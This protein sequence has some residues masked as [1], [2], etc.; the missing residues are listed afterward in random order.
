MAKKNIF[1]GSASESLEIAKAIAQA[2]AESDYRS[3]RWW[4]EFPAGSITLD[5]LLE[6]SKS[7]D[8]AVFLCT[9]L[10]K[11]WYRQELSQVPRDNLILEYGIFVTRLGRERTLVLKDS[12]T[13]L[14]SDIAAI[15]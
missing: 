6:L 1:I 13:R 5:R 12:D 9:G 10:D 7:V 15:S 11:R 3:L 14:P 8:G 2:L 4:Q